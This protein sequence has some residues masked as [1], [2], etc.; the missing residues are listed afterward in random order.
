M[1]CIDRTNTNCIKYDSIISKY[2]KDVIPAWIADMD[3]KTAPEIIE[4]FIKRVEHGVFGYTFRSKNYYEAIVK[5]YEKRYKC[6]IDPRWIVDGPGVVPMI[7]ILINTLTHPGDKIIIQPP[8]Y[9]PFFATIRNNGRIITENRLKRTQNSYRMD[10]DNL[11]KI[12]DEKTKLI[13]ISNPHNPVGRVWTYQELEKLYSVV[14]KYNLIVISDEI[15]ADIVYKPNEFT[16][17]LKIGQ[18]NIIVLNSPGK[19]F[20]VPGL[21]NSYGLIPDEG[22]RVTYTKALEKLELTTGN[23]FGITALCVAYSQGE[24]WLAELIDY[25]Q[26]NRDYVYEFVKNNMPLI[27]ITLPEGTFLM[28]LDCSKLGLENPQQYF[29]YNVR[30]YLNNGADFGDPNSVRL[31]IACSREKLEQIMQRMKKAYDLLIKG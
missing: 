20:N 23:V 7:A 25:L 30:V 13:I 28:W 4:E 8:V 6:S 2:G 10:Y 1:D 11:E 24:K 22:L 29:L 3:F 16:S 31:N 17:L 18:K 9:P 26:T 27:D 19:T 14:L 5:W 21:T 15:H 12:I